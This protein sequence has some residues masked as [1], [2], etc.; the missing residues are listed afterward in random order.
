MELVRNLFGSTIGKKLLMAATGLVL[1]GFV[2]GHL[3]GN[4][5]VFEDPD[6][7]NGY[8][9]LLQS[10]GP[11][12]WAMRILLL[13]CV[14]VHIWAGTVLA[15]EDRKARGDEPYAVNTWIRATVSSRYMRWTGF[16]VLAFILYHLA[17]FTVGAA[18]AGTFKGNLQH[19]TMKADYRVMGFAAVRAGTDVLDVRSMVILGFRKRVVALFYI[20]AVGL[21]SLHLL[22]GADSLFQTLGWRSS[23]WERGLKAVVALFCAAYFLG[24]LS[25]PGAALLGF[26]R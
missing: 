13:A 25:I 4:L 21:L 20:V 3:V 22:H 23:R 1:I 26:L 2:T 5:Q 24:N 17:Q 11:A 7:I 16:V 12:L 18:Q 8:A 9:H 6:K 14:T 15:I 19:Y 10:L